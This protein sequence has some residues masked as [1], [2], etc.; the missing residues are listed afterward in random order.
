MKKIAKL[1]T[2]LLLCAIM[3]TACAQPSTPATSSA[4][5]TSSATETSSDPATAQV[6]ADD[7]YADVQPLAES[8]ELTIGQ[9]NGSG[10]GVVSYFIEQLGGF[11]KVGITPKYVVFGNGPVMVEAL[12]ANGWDVGTYGIGGTLTGVLKQE[13]YVIASA[14]RN[15]DSQRIFA[16]A[17]SDIVKAGHTVTDSP[18]VYGST[19]TWKGKEI[20]L[21]TGTTL[22]Y[23]LAKA[24]E[25]FGL[26]DADV[27][28]TS[29]DVNSANT[30]MKAD[31]GEVWAL[32]G[33]VAYSPDPNK[34]VCVVKASDVGA[35]LV[36]TMVANVNSYNDPQKFEAIK[37]WADLYFKTIDWM[38][39]DDNIDKA[40]QMYMDWSE[41]IG[42]KTT[43]EECKE[44]LVGGRGFNLKENYDMFNTKSPDGKMTLQEYYNY[45]PLLFFISQGNYQPEDA[46]K[47]L[48]GYFKSDI[49]NELYQASQNK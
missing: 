29:M 23:T 39:S 34:Y 37:K 44:L 35:D 12:A 5:E 4:P 38:F 1:V 32:F 10:D 13:T 9:L 18:D 25:K 45:E 47:F 49:V 33:S 24:L 6:A 22:H 36:T 3:L 43:V 30:A 15:S 41:S 2:A 19:D 14:A 21:P 16:R 48:G 26:T 42:V 8:T 27:K 7:P 40:A 11:E 31:K 28:L 46:D 17:D 20:Y